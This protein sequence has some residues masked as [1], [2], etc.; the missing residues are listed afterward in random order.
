MCWVKIAA[1]NDEDEIVGE[2]KISFGNLRLFTALVGL[3][4]CVHLNSLSM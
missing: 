4:M 2:A 1:A 3:T